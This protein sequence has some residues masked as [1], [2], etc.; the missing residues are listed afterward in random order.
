[1]GQVFSFTTAI[2][3]YGG[4]GGRSVSREDED[5]INRGS[6]GNTTMLVSYI[7]ICSIKSKVDRILNDIYLNML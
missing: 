1:M 2:G 7:V 4:P 3:T 5:T 6:E